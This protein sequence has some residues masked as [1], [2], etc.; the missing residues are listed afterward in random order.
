MGGGGGGGGKRLGGGGAGGCGILIVSCW[1]VEIQFPSR[2]ATFLSLSAAASHLV[3]VK[4][5]PHCT[6]SST[7]SLNCSLMYAS[8]RSTAMARVCSFLWNPS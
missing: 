5:A 7:S 2:M 4:L 8:S 3:D 6:R 1:G